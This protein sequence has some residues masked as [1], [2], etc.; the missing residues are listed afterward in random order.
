MKEVEF[1]SNL[2]RHYYQTGNIKKAK[3]I[4]EKLVGTKEGEKRSD[5][6]EVGKAGEF[7]TGDGD[8]D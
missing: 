8:Q 7:E 4:H 5:M 3:D 1:K 2:M 6:G